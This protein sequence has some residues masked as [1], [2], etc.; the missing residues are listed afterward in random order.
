MRRPF[1]RW[2]RNLSIGAA[3][4]L[5][6]TVVVGVAGAQRPDGGQPGAGP[7]Q[8]GPGGEMFGELRDEYV[9]H[10]AANLGLPE[11]TVRDALTKTRDEMRP[12]LQGRFQQAR[13]RFQERTQDPASRDQMREQFRDRMQERFREQG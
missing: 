9:S 1:G 5:L 7:G 2:A 10:L 3:V 8:R 11:Q 4:F 12:L 13:E 6:F